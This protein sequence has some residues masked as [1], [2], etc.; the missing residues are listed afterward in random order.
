MKKPIQK[1]ITYNNFIIKPQLELGSVSTEYEPYRGQNFT[2]NADGTVEGVTSISP[3]MT[4]TTD[5]NGVII[6]AEYNKD[7]NKVIEQLTNAII[8]LG[9]TI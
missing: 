2:P 8:S 1:D 6:E 9:G 4:L 7:T 3:T 5:K